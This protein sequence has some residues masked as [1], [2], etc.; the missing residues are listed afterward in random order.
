M[1][2]VSNDNTVVK[3]LSINYLSSK[4]ENDKSIYTAVQR[5]LIKLVNYSY[6]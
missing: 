5:N 6:T 2:I 1:Y 4:E 3:L